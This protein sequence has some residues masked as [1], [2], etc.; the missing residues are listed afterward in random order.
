[1]LPMAS[2]QRRFSPTLDQALDSSA[3]PLCVRLLNP[4]DSSAA[5]A[6][7]P[8]GLLAH[9]CEGLQ[10]LLDALLTRL[11]D[12]DLDLLHPDSI[13]T[14]PSAARD[15][16]PPPFAGR[17][18]AAIVDCYRHVEQATQEHEAAQSLVQLCVTA[19]RR[20]AAAGAGPSTDPS[21]LLTVLEELL[22][23]IDDQRRLQ[24][25]RQIS[26]LSDSGLPVDPALWPY[27]KALRL[28]EGSAVLFP[29]AVGAT[30]EGL[31]SGATVL[32][33]VAAVVA[34]WQ[35]LHAAL[36]RPLGPQDLRSVWPYIR[37][38]VCRVW[39]SERPGAPFMARAREVLAAECEL[40]WLCRSAGAVVSRG[41]AERLAQAVEAVLVVHHCHA[42]RRLVGAA[43]RGT[44]GGLDV[45]VGPEVA[46]ALARLLHRGAEDPLALPDYVPAFQALE[47]EVQPL[48]PAPL[49]RLLADAKDAVDLLGDGLHAQWDVIGS[50]VECTVA[51]PSNLFTQLKTDK[52]RAD[53]EF[54]GW[55]YRTLMTATTAVSTLVTAFQPV[56]QALRD[57]LP[58]AWARRAGDA[59]RGVCG[60]GWGPGGPCAR[61]AH[62][63]GRA[64]PA[65]LHGGRLPAGHPGAGL[66]CDAEGPHAHHRGRHHH[67]RRPARRGPGRRDPGT[68][69]R[70]PAR[71]AGPRGRA[72]GHGD[73]GRRDRTLRRTG[74]GSARAWRS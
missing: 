38:V 19:A 53:N 44:V 57:H 9:V 16:C 25:T 12:K 23:V 34:R 3:R 63:G 10:K 61:A 5:V 45:A 67:G 17:L 35:A 24:C 37:E 66:P 2:T 49:Q 56:R 43:R 28:A 29:V 69:A 6:V 26:A 41:V 47:A 32:D 54:L 55:K 21:P 30:L 71:G 15:L 13:A 46:H 8:D 73:P 48:L 52:F 1:M 4:P 7:L 74:T 40:L 18:D 22:Q 27:L 31:P 72:A 51:G 65:R 11:E 33:L 58:A 68:R 50:L 60:P 36:S 14:A 39:Q 70:G 64:A 62:A 20:H 42:L 59:A